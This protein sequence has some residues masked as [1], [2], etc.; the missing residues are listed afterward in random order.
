MIHDEFNKRRHFGPKL[1]PLLIVV[2]TTWLTLARM[3]AQESHMDPTEDPIEPKPPAVRLLMVRGAEGDADFASD[4]GEAAQ[5]WLKVA[6]RN[7]FEVIE[8]QPETE[9]PARDV[10]RNAIH[11]SMECQS[12]WVVMIGH[13]TFS[14]NSAK[15]NLPGPDVSSEELAEWF[16]PFKNDLYLIHCFSA[17]APFMKALSGPGRIVVTSTKSGAEYNYSRFGKYL[18]VAMNELGNDLDHDDSV[19]LLEAFL[20]ANN[21]T[22][23]FYESESRLAT[24]HALLDDNSD[25]LGTPGEFYT[26]IRPSQKSESGREIDGARASRIILFESPDLPKLDEAQSQDRLKLELELEKLRRNKPSIPE[27]QYLDRLETLMLKLSPLYIGKE[28][29]GNAP[30]SETGSH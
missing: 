12:L 21:R 28:A 14:S 3:H 16:V 11:D 24:E 27:S 20:A 4:F 10:L 19:S 6:E 5:G 26:G 1:V 23:Q 7:N 8:I 17:S 25:T 15:F 22:Q 9:E 29:P 13:G 30:K 18:G 2:M